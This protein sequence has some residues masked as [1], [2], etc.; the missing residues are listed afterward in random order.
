MEIVKNLLSIVVIVFVSS[1]RVSANFQLPS[2][3]SMRPGAVWPEPVRLP[4]GRH[5]Q[6]ID[7]LL[8][9][10]VK[11]HVSPNRS[12]SYYLVVGDQYRSFLYPVDPCSSFPE[13]QAIH[14][15]LSS[16]QRRMAH[17]RIFITLN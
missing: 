15:Y 6:V 8:E 17:F 5:Q 13:N 2:A 11:A 16:Q 10:T 14:S 3:E 4:L 9:C 12:D 7:L 1:P